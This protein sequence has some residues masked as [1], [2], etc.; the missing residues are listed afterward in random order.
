MASKG[1]IK[2]KPRGY[3]YGAKLTFPL[4]LPAGGTRLTVVPIEARVVRCVVGPPE[5]LEHWCLPFVGQDRTV[6]ECRIKQPGIDE[7]FYLDAESDKQILWKITHGEG[8]PDLGG[9]RQLPIA[10]LI[11]DPSIHS[12]YR[13]EYG[14]YDSVGK[15]RAYRVVHG[16]NGYPEV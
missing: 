13:V 6:I 2:S 7:L 4:P 8:R 10:R 16:H 15:R 1:S 12:F 9:I 14:G 3:V 11:D 5:E